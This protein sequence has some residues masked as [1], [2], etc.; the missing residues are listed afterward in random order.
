M[1]NVNFR[2]YIKTQYKLGKQAIEIFNQLKAV[3]NDQ[4]PSYATVARWVA[5]FKNGRESIEDDPRSGR[6]ITG[7]TQDNIDAVRKVIVEDP[8][9]TY[10]EIEAYTSLSCGTINRIIHEHLKLRKVVARWVPHELT[11]ENRRKRVKDCR[12]NL[13]L[14]REGKWRLCDVVTGDESWFFY[15]QIGRKQD[16]A[17]WIGEGEYAKPVVR[18]SQFEPKIMVSVFFRSTGLVHIHFLK[19]GETINAH[20]YIRNC[21]EPLTSSINEQ[22]PTSGTKNMKFHHDNAKPHVAK[23]VKSYLNSNGFTIIRHPPYS[24]DL[25]PSDFWL[26]DYIKRQLTDHTNRKSLE[27]E[28]TEILENIP[29]EEYQKTFNKWLERM[30]LCIQNQ[31]HYFEHLINK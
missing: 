4:A 8:H 29:K 16:N 18:R 28:I 26:F 21:L 14:F 25:A 27:K 20:N 13:K 10:N 3:Y 22:R 11:D 6:P 30:E 23:C 12:E 2:F 7:V 31:G 1:E 15:R 5:L 9:S 24:P 19:N 17:T